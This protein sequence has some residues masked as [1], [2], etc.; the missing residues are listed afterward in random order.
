MEYRVVPRVTHLS[1]L[2]PAEGKTDY[3]AR[4]RLIAQDKNKYNTPK[5]RLVVRFSN[6]DITCQVVYAKIEG[7]VVLAA[8]YAHELPLYGV[9]VGLSNYAAAYCTG[10]LLARRV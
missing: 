4:K 8:A 2:H 3:Y 7:D 1:C 6:Q 10:L 9:T 5:Y